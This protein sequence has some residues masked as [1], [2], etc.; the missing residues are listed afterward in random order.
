MTLALFTLLAVLVVALAFDLTN[1]F[2]DAGNAMATSIA[3][4]ALK[5]RT[6]VALAGFL[7]LVGALLSVEVALTVTNGVV[8]LQ[9]KEGGLKTEAFV[10]HGAA[11]LTVL[12]AALA[13]AIL[14][15]L[16]TWYR[17]M[18]SSSSHALF[19]GLI[20][21]TLASLGTAGVKWTEEGK[22]FGGGVLGKVL[23]PALLSPTLAFLVAALMTW[24][25]TLVL[26]RTA[27]TAERRAWFRRGQIAT[28]CTV[29]LS[30]G[31]NDAQKT[32][33]IMAL[34]LG[35]YSGAV[36]EIPLWV[37]LSCAGALALGTYMGGWR[38]M[39]TM[40]KGLVE[41]TPEQGMMAEASGA[42]VIFGSSAAGMALSTT[43]VISGSILGSGVGYPGA[44]VQWRVAGSMALAWML[45]LPGAALAAFL[46][47]RVALLVGAAGPALLLVLL[48]LGSLGFWG[49]ARRHPSTFAEEQETPARLTGVALGEG[50][51][52][53]ITGKKKRQEARL[54]KAPKR[55]RETKETGSRAAGM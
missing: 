25:L 31:M 27:A 51:I 23:V 32:M 7:N 16:F 10:N 14:W 33:G 39:R 20:G 38:I 6:A 28:A 53:V 41:L 40:G 49:L 43:H 2:H 1:G 55:L 11:I 4:G 17:S 9:N 21:A 29:A 46:L 13:G 19:G 15:N 3:T 36:G 24:V 45:T 30:H 52:T 18:P 22:L 48:V 54:M 26:K 8:R 42:A 5:P 37:R 34:A 50:G 47:E 44:R 12:L 35:A